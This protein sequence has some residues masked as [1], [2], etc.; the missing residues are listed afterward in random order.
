MALAIVLL[1]SA[2]KE[3]DTGKPIAGAVQMA[4][5]VAG[6]C[7]VIALGVVYADRRGIFLRRNVAITR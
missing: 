2:R 3:Y 4:V 1:C 7:T 5:L 6:L